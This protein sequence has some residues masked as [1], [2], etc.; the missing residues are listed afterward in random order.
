V[1]SRHDLQP[2]DI[3][4]VIAHVHQGAIDVLGTVVDP[5]T[6]HQAKFSM[7]TVLAMVASYRRAGMSEFDAHFRNDGV[8]AFRDKVRMTLDDEV[9][10][11]YPARWIG[12]VTVRTTRGETLAGRVDEPKGD[13]GNTLSRDELT[14][15]ALRLGRY[16]DAADDDE[17]G[18]AIARIW[19]LD[20]A[21]SV[22]SLLAPR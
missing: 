17:L 13:P 2:D 22:G 4:E 16:S 3:A 9:D 10:R 8:I 18:A 12:K 15:K 7:G 21:P 11:A 1:V 6:V 14:D 5:T 20:D 19:T